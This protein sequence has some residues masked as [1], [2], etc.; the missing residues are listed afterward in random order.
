M[1]AGADREAAVQG[2]QL[3]H[4]GPVRQLDALR[5]AR[6]A[7]GVDDREEVVAAGLVESGVDARDHLLGHRAIARRKV[8][9]P[10]DIGARAAVE[11]DHPAQARD[12]FGRLTHPLGLVGA[13][14]KRH[15]HAAVIGDVHHLIDGVG[16]VDGHRDGADELARQVNLGP[17]GAIARVETHPVA[18]LDTGV[19]ER[20]G[21]LHGAGVELAVAG[22][23]PSLAHQHARGGTVTE[24]LH[25]RLHHQADVRRLDRQWL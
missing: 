11:A 19:H 9:E 21:D 15:H 2:T 4:D 7:G 20:R 13:S 22:H 17:F 14:G 25:T 8:F 6:G 16:G 3:R 18:L 5:G 1:V 10:G 12:A 23:H 24:G